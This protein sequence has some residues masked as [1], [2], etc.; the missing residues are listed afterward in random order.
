MVNKYDLILFLTQKKSNFNYSPYR[1]NS[2][3][4][5]NSKKAPLKKG[6]LLKNKY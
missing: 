1:L 5:K 6:G 2:I 3:L 4:K